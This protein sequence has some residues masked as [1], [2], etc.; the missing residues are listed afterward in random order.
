[1]AATDV[2]RERLAACGAELPLEL[3]DLIVAV[4]GPL[5]TA[6]DDLLTLD[7]GDV[8]P[9]VPTVRLVADAADADSR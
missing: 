7:L 3:L 4:A 6:L 8:E 5:L 9:F 1:M 2:L